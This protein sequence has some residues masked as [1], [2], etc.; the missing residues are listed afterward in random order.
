[1]KKY[2]RYICGILTIAA[3]LGTGVRWPA[4]AVQ[5]AE[6]TGQAGMGTPGEDAASTQ[7][8][9]QRSES[10]QTPAGGDE[11]I[12][13]QPSGGAGT[14]ESGQ[15]S[16]GEDE[17]ES[18]QPSG[19]AG[20]SESGQP[21]GGGDASEST[22]TSGGAGTSESMPPSG[23][24][25][26]SESGQPSGGGDASESTQTS[27]GAG[28]SESGQPSGGESTSESTQRPGGGD[29]SES[30]QPSGGE[31]ASESAQESQAGQTPE[32]GQ[33]PGEKARIPA[34]MDQETAEWIRMAGEALAEIA[35][36]RDIMALVYL[37]DE[38]PVRV[39]PS[40]DSPAAVTVLSGQTVNILDLAVDEN[41]EVWHYV[42]L[43][44][45][46]QE[47]CGYVPR[48]YLACA[49]ERFL[50]W[51]ETFG[52]NASAYNVD[53][54]G[55][56]PDIEQFP[57]SYRPMLLE[58]KKTHP[59]WTFAKMNTTLDWGDV[60]SNEL[61]YGRSLVYKT[62]PEWAKNGLYD[63]GNWYYA[64]R[65]ALELYMDPRNS[66]TEKAIFQFEQLTYNEAY[67]TQEAVANF[68]KNTF[69][70]DNDGKVAPGTNTSYAK[71]FWEVGREE[72]RKVSPFH[73]AARVLQ[74]QGDGTSPL[75]SGTYPGYEGY[76]NYFNIK[77]SGTTNEEIYRQGLQYAKEQG[78]SNADSAIRGGADF[79]SANYIKRAQDTLYLQ[80][81][82]V[83][84]PGTPNAYA[85]YTH[86]YMQN[87]MAPTTEGLSIKKLYS[88]AGALDNTFV[89]K[90]PVYE[91]MPA[92]PCAEPVV[93]M[94][95][96][97]ALP[98]GYG[99]N[100]LWLDGVPYQGE[101]RNGSLIVTAPHDKVKTAV[102]Y[103]YDESG[104]ARGMYVW[105]L[106]HNGTVYTATAQPGL[107]D[108][109]TYHGFSIRIKGKTGIRVKTGIS[110]DLRAQLIRP[111]VDGYVLKEYGTLVMNSANMSQYPMIKDGAKVAGSISYGIDS[112]G[113]MKDVAFELAEGRYRFTG[114]LVGIPVEQYKTEFAF[115]GYAVLERNGE[116]VVI[117][118][119][120]RAR[121]IY[122][123]AKAML[124]SG[125]YEPGS[126]SY[127]FLEKLINDADAI[128]TETQE[129]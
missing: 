50:G 47:I 126:E 110:K 60:I 44:Y 13:G 96:A 104:V 78:W 56:Y 129:N 31:D 17:S 59:N 72:G 87:I 121:S 15:P 16:G 41:M 66:L 23:G 3:L 105:S 38:Y 36:D 34:G 32:S 14:S 100:V 98:E 63:T 71:L 89:F 125:G 95:V 97:V 1:M 80:K 99:D 94:E 51:E 35:A 57:E 5:A 115:R 91:N 54:E 20:T 21:S 61:L 64:S 123:L 53:G 29:A 37:S 74:E 82:N 49:D 120:A 19:G 124:E 33:T 40:Y 58:L 112:S 52:L 93:S 45:M 106:A 22:Q 55:N 10:L 127:V 90:I 81:F 7:R 117:Y 70:T 85:T 11:W 12:S 26:T 92:Q 30:T 9:T 84:P 88:E 75:I 43:D 27:G 102:L 122:D 118:G 46:N 8:S 25:G 62:L 119:P 86:Q 68:L 76:Y 107:Q 108:L 116:Q 109:L 111:G 73:L 39:S 79:I 113:S 28:T 4:P 114:V 42:K 77:A 67:H 101:L 65:A 24:A 128:Q 6:E 2:G 69:M 18:G 103:R 48:T 83:N